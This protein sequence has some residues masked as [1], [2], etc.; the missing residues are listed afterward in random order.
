MPRK[1]KIKR[2]KSKSFSRKTQKRF[3]K[4]ISKNEDQ[5]FE[6]ELKLMTTRPPVVSNLFRSWF[7]HNNAIDT[8]VKAELDSNI[9]CKHRDCGK[10]IMN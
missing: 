10:Y 1:G 6:G 7:N 8:M 4:Q 2:G 9:K 3:V 5:S